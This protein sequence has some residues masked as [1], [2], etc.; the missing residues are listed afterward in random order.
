MEVMKIRP[1]EWWYDHWSTMLYVETVVVDNGGKL[2]PD[3]MRTS[4]E[5]EK[6][7]NYVQ[8]RHRHSMEREHPTSFLCL[9]ER[10]WTPGLALQHDDWSCLED[11]VREGYMEEPE[12]YTG[13]LGPVKLTDKGWDL[14]HQLRRLRGMGHSTKEMRL[15]EGKIVVME[16]GDVLF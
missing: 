7:Q 15:S 12:T 11:F 14:A 16:K 1:R 4:F 3:K 6:H 8:A 10:G 2:A 5:N 13:F 9:D